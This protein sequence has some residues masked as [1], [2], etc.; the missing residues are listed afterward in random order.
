[1]W[2]VIIVCTASWIGVVAGEKD[3]SDEELKQFVSF[4][5]DEYLAEILVDNLPAVMN[6]RISEETTYYE[7]GYPI[8]GVLIKQGDDKPIG[9]ALNNHIDFII[10][11]NEKESKDGFEIVGF[12]VAPRR[13]LF[14][15]CLSHSIVSTT[16]TRIWY[17]ELAVKNELPPW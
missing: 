8:G 2:R 5:N 12:E 14:S 3:Y 4:I 15:F 1:M 6:V 13:Y 7:H 10:S 11:Y 16:A 9:Y 17:R